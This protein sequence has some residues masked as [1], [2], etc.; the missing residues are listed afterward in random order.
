MTDKK[1]RNLQ[2]YIGNNQGQ[3]EEQ[4]IEH[5]SKINSKTPLTQE[6]WKKLIFPCCNNGYADVLKF[7]LDNIDIPD[8]I[9]EYMEHTVYGRRSEKVITGRIKVLEILME[10][11]TEDKTKSLSETMIWAAWFGETEIVKFL[12]ANGADKM[13]QDENGLNL[14]KC[15]ERVKKQFKD[16]SLKEFLAE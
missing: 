14:E 4:I 2:S 9:L 7:I 11:L 13:Y 3:T 10:Y 16:S 5:I 8:N 15:A 1:L 6:E 12:I